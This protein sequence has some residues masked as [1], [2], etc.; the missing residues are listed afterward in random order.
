MIKGE[1]YTA[2]AAYGARVQKREGEKGTL[3]LVRE[4]RHS[5]GKVWQALTEPHICASGRRS[6]W[7]GIWAKSEPCSSHG[8]ERRRQ[9][10]QK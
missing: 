10:R 9:S 7:M 2:G 4:L 1:E 3:I 6:M 8:W 5:R